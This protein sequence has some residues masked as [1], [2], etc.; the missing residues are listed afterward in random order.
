MLII[1]PNKTLPPKSDNHVEE[2]EREWGH[3]ENITL[4]IFSFYFLFPPSLSISYI[5]NCLILSQNV[6]YDTCVANVTKSFSYVQWENNSGSNS[7]R[8]SSASCA[9]L[10]DDNLYET[11]SIRAETRRGL[12]ICHSSQTNRRLSQVNCSRLLRTLC[13][14]C[15][16]CQP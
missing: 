6:K 14:Y 1:T 7:L 8:E 4:Y 13:I 12:G 10:G 5:K 9:G 16:Y 2:M 3:G 15:L 11:E